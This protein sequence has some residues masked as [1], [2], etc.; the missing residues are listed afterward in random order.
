MFKS[1]HESTL[2]SHREFGRRI[3]WDMRIKTHVKSARVSMTIW[4]KYLGTIAEQNNQ[5]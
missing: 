1:E 2:E 4:R 5:K 3:A